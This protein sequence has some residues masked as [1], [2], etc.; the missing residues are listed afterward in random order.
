MRPQMLKT[1][2]NNKKKHTAI[3]Q[4]EVTAELSTT[5]T[6]RSG[7]TSCLSV[8]PVSPSLSPT[9]QGDAGAKEHAHGPADQI[10]L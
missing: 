8:S 5:F 1:I 2:V 4:V 6:H 7:T 9:G 3:K 10:A